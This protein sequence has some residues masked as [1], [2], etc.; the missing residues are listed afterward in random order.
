MLLLSN[1]LNQQFTS[2]DLFFIVVFMCVMTNLMSLMLSV[3]FSEASESWRL[4]PGSCLFSLI[5]RCVSPYSQVW[6]LRACCSSPI[7]CGRRPC[8]TAGWMTIGSCGRRHMGKCTRARWE[9]QRA[10]WKSSLMLEPSKYFTLCAICVCWGGGGE[11]QRIVGE[12]PDAHHPAQ[13][14]SFDGTSHLR[15][16][17]ELH[18]RSGPTFFTSACST[19]RKGWIHYAECIRVWESQLFW[20]NMVFSS[21]VLTSWIINCSSGCILWTV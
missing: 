9:T 7:V 13:P 3:W 4:L 21:L 12:E 11:P 1:M 5:C 15:P 19:I 10:V 18:G 20:T 6:C 17:H 2:S 8:L 16:E 14:G